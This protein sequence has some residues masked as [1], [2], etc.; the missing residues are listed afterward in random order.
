LVYSIRP[1]TSIDTKSSQT[2]AMAI[3]FAEN[4]TK[5][6]IGSDDKAIGYIHID[7]FGAGWQVLNAALLREV[8]RIER[9]VVMCIAFNGDVTQVGV[10]YRGFPLSVWEINEA[11]CIGRCRRAKQPR[12]D[13]SRPSSGWFAVDRFTW[14]PVTGHIIGIYKVG[15]I[16][17]WHPVTNENQEVQSAADEVAASPDGKLFVTSDSNGTIK[18]WN[19]AYFSIIY[20][21]S[22]ADLVTGLAL[23]PDCWRFYD[24]RGSCLNAWE[25]NSLIRFSETE[26]SFSDTGS[27][28]QVSISVPQAL[29]AYLV[30]Y[31]AVT[32]LAIPQNT[33]LY[34]VGI[35]EGVLILFNAATGESIEPTRFLNLLS[36]SLLAWSQDTTHIAATDLGGEI[37]V[38]RLTLPDDVS[39]KSGHEIKSM[40]SPKL[41]FEGRGIYQLLFSYDSKSLLVICDDQGQIWSI[42]EGTLRGSAVLTNG[43]SRKWFN[44]PTQT[45]LFL[46]FGTNDV[47]VFQCRD[48][49][50][51]SCLYFH[52]DRSRV[53]SQTTFDGQDDKT[54]ELRKLSLHDRDGLEF[55]LIVNKAILTQDEK[56]LLVQINH[57]SAQG[58]INEKR[59][60]IIIFDNSAFGVFGEQKFIAPSTYFSLSVDI[61]GKIEVPL[62]IL[63]GSRFVFLD[64]DLWICILNL[65]SMFDEEPLEAALFYTQRLGE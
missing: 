12:S 64:Q 55:V 50:E 15:C 1:S 11:R 7:D 32:A 38:K 53:N 65:G 18:V 20:Q 31:E 23:S 19:F 22:S 43:I 63:T 58:R 6:L 54:M 16:S 36:V 30:Q 35:E 59:N 49:A 9:T 33:S 3:V 25:S 28:H 44:H 45:H 5:A 8:P 62:D 57:T 51:Q 41:N 46:G 61:M 17:K 27:E 52:E 47:E 39:L 48:F 40:P 56:H 26:E 37:V 34:S 21:L 42:D 14:N 4:D 24:L 2:K 60:H 29:E 13:L 10:S